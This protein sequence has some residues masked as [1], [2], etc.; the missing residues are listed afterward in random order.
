MDMITMLKRKT[1][2]AAQA[3][4][5][6][7][8]S[9]KLAALRA[10]ERALAAE[11]RELLKNPPGN[12]RGA[13][14]LDHA[15]LAPLAA[16]YLR[17]AFELNEDAPK[18]EQIGIELQVVRHAA[19]DLER[20]R[21]LERF[22]RIHDAF[23]QDGHAW[24]EAVRATALCIANLQGLNQKR[25]AMAKEIRQGTLLS[26]P[27]EFP[28]TGGRILGFGNG[29]LPGDGGAYEYLR[30]VV[31]A[32]ICTQNEIDQARANAAK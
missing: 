14:L 32:G 1:P 29:Q 3:P 22:K 11:Q 7:T 28:A 24:R 4:A 27:C 8:H 25:A 10:R 9:D 26:L 18:L 30:Q 12:Q 17:G 16:K 23:Q 19:D 20:Q 15:L 2:T 5:G 13:P 6:E 31:T 21:E